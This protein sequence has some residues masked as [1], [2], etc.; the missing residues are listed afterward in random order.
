MRYVV[1]NTIVL[2]D[3]RPWLSL[4]T[5]G[6]MINTTPQVLSNI[7]DFGMDPPKACDVPRMNP[8]TDHYDVQ[9]ESRIPESV[10]AGLAKMG[11]LVRAQA[12]YSPGMS[13]FQVCWR[14]E[15]S[16]LL[17]SCTDNRGVGK[18]DGF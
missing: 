5:P 4:G 7:L 12:P 17:H 11:I 14:D 3:G 6:N 15:K 2:K 8:L 10:V 13:S 18:A 9:V 16:G 1:A